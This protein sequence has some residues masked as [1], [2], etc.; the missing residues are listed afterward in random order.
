[1]KPTMKPKLLLV[2]ATLAACTTVSNAADEKALLGHIMWSAFECS[3]YAELAE[4]K[5]EQERLYLVGLNAGRTFLE[6]MKAGQIPEQAV[7]EAVPI[8][9]L[10]RLKGPSNEMVIGKIHAA[11]TGSARDEIVKQKRSM[12][13]ST[14]KQEARSTYANRNCILIR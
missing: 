6:A 14:Q 5:T 8:N 9:V 4:E 7:N 12:W 13:G 11:A 10:Q 1:M 3:A 2:A